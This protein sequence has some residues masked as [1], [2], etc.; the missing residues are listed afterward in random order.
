[1]SEV[2]EKIVIDVKKLEE[3]KKELRKNYKKYKEK[4]KD[5]NNRSRIWDG[6]RM[7]TTLEMGNFIDFLLEKGDRI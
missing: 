2:D 7:E 6:V 3:Y 1:M 4:N 5:E